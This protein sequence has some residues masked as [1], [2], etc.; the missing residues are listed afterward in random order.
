MDNTEGTRTCGQCQREV[1]EANFA[2]HES[3]CSRF[4][5]LCPDCNETVP[6]DQL[7]QHREEQHTQVKCSKC[8]K[9]M[10]RC[11]LLDH[12]SDECVERLQ[13]C[14]FCE[15]E[16]VWKH[17][18]EHRVVCGSRTELCKDCGCY[19]M[20]RD[21]PEHILTCSTSDQNSAPS[22]AASNAASSATTMMCSRCLGS[23]STDDIDE[24][25][26]ECCP[27]S[28]WD[29]EEAEP[30]REEK[31]GKD[32]SSGQGAT[33][34]LSGTFKATSLTQPQLSGPRGDRGDL[35]EISTC[36]HCHLALPI[37][38]LRWHE[39]KCQIHIFLKLREG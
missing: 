28:R 13:K 26:A 7:T 37:I 2:L 34:L 24:H 14:D 19:V 4:L 1:A 22:P 23:F 25:E 8:N 9:K 12:E 18:D 16:V 15:L 30:K 32:D 3:H 20:L 29:D 36:P 11:Q 33:A 10:E 21:Q 6:R 35:V 38:I 39:V 5:C 27:A 17:L 31:E